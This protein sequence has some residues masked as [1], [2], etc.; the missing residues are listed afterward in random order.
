MVHEIFRVEL[1]LNITFFFLCCTRKQPRISN[2]LLTKM[3]HL[4]TACGLQ[5]VSPCAMRL[6]VIA[7]ESLGFR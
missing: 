3:K 4:I 6:C 2:A 5:I 7:S 1:V